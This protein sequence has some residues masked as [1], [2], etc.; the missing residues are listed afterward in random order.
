MSISIEIEEINQK[1][2]LNQKKKNKNFTF[3]L[4]QREERKYRSSLCS[5]LY[6]LCTT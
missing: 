6:P 5:S 3:S 1:K 2:F 4:L